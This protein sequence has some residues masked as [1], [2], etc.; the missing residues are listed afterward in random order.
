MQTRV[1]QLRL[2]TT[3]SELLPWPA[4]PP[5]GCMDCCLGEWSLGTRPRCGRCIE[6]RCG[7]RREAQGGDTPDATILRPHLTDPCRSGLQR[8]SGTTGQG[9]TS[10]SL[11]GIFFQNES[12]TGE[13][14]TAILMMCAGRIR[15]V[16]ID[17]RDLGPQ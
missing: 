3:H 12:Q 9:A 2:S 7:T 10:Q 13:G 6:G 16:G 15:N 11:A 4:A 17:P 14:C 1:L 8:E 5:R